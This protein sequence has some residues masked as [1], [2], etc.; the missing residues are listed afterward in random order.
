MHDNASRHKLHSTQLQ[1]TIDPPLT[2]TLSKLH[3]QLDRLG[4]FLTDSAKLQPIT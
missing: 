2:Y 1:V 4:H 3:A